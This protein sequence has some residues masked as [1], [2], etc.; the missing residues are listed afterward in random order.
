MWYRKLLDVEVYVRSLFEG[1]AHPHL[2]YHNLDHTLTVVKR[3]GEIAAQCALGGYQ[4]F[5][6]L[7]AAWFHDVGQLFAHMHEHEEK[8][9]EVMRA[10]FAVQHPGESEAT[11]QAI[12]QCILATRM[13][14][15]PC[16]LL[17]EIICDADTYHLGTEAFFTTDQQVKTE[18]E[19]RLCIQFQEWEKKA[20]AFL[21]THQYYTAYCRSRL[22]EGKQQN[23]QV[24]AGRMP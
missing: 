15:C 20:Y 13:P 16:D 11:L 9:V 12:A 7:T 2:I 3:A 23:M 21:E 1:N 19:L 14:V 24:L 5:V 10:Y 8:S 4:Q 6:L 18:L 17:Q 22:T